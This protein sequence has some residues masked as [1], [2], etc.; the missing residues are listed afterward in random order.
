MVLQ[1]VHAQSRKA[2]VLQD[3][4]FLCYLLSIM[5]TV[6]LALQNLLCF[7]SDSYFLILSC[8]A[9][10]FLHRALIRPFD[11]GPGI[12]PPKNLLDL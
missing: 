3:G 6:G 11:I 12:R 10:L 8:R 7:R 5:S 4:Q 2:R 9:S 1:D